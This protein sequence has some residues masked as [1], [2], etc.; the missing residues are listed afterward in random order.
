VFVEN[1][2]SKHVREGAS[3]F[4]TLN[5]VLDVAVDGSGGVHFFGGSNNIFY[6]GPGMDAP[7][8]IGSNTLGVASVGF[9]VTPGGVPHAI[10]L[11]E[12]FNHN[13]YGPYVWTRDGT[14]WL[15]E[16]RQAPQAVS[17]VSLTAGRASAPVALL[18]GQSADLVAQPG[19]GGWTYSPRALF[20]TSLAVRAD[21]TPVVVGIPPG[22]DNGLRIQEGDTASDISLGSYRPYWSAVAVDAAGRTHLAFT[23]LDG[24]GQRPDAIAYAVHR[25]GAWAVEWVAQHRTYGPPSLAVDDSGTPHLA[26]TAYDSMDVYYVK[27]SAAE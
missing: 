27:R 26:F 11:E 12:D 24:Q 18:D 9:D 10:S 2:R 25:D 23:V 16:T 5:N 6:Q 22:V 13:R 14:S 17:R 3:E 19:A 1:A 7:Q 15:A 20:N 4:L 21:G 8:R